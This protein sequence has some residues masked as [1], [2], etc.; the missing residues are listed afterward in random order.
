MVNKQNDRILSVDRNT[1]A[2]QLSSFLVKT[3]SAM[4]S[5]EITSDD[6]TPLAFI[7]KVSKLIKQS[8]V[9]PF[10]RMFRTH[11]PENTLKRGNG[12]SDRILL[13]LTKLKPP[14]SSGGSIFQA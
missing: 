7:P 12:H 1:L 2:Q 5:A 13:L 3:D 14:K 4:V 8:I 10:W 6:W 11:G 9:K